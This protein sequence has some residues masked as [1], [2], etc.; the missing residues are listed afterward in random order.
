[1]ERCAKDA[2]AAPRHAQVK[3][4]MPKGGGEEDSTAR[5]VMRVE[6]AGWHVKWAL[7]WARLYSLAIQRPA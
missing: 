6:N 2:H 5:L 1:M 7:S 3:L 4:L